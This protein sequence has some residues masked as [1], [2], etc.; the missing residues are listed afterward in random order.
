MDRLYAY[1]LLLSEGYDVWDEYNKVLDELFLSEPENEEYLYLEGISDIK[2]TVLCLLAQMQQNA[3]DVQIFGSTFMNLL[4]EAY[5]K[6][7]IYKF[8]RHMYLIWQKLPDAL[9]KQEPFLCLSY[10]DDPLS[11]GDEKQSRELYEDVMN[12]FQKEKK[13]I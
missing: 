10:A 6:D 12:Y 3:V 4:W 11:W 13:S 8:G 9:Q 2:T 1:A 5:S 7:D